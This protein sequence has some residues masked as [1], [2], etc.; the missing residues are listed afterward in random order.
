MR[1]WREADIAPFAA[2]NADSGVMRFFPSVL[3]PER[4][5]TMVKRIESQFDE[6]GFGLW[7]IEIGGVF[8]G[9]TGLNVTA[10][11]TPIGP[12]VE[13]GWRFASWAWGNGYAT[14][15]ANA[16][17]QDGF[18]KHDMAEIYSFTTQSNERS[19][20]VMRRIGMQS[21]ADLDFDHPD[22]PGWWGQRHAV[23]QLTA[24]EWRER[25]DPRG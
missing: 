24:D 4:S 22:T 1:R 20:A 10:F 14:E 5:E 16:A 6:R 12:H 11:D 23:Y 18:V 9:F 8:A 13:I 17:L 21:R 25:T 2:M 3:S 19:E 7:A 15:A